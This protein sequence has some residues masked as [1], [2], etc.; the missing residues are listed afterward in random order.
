MPKH[1]K[2][3]ANVYENGF[4]KF[5]V[6]EVVLMKPELERW[7]RRNAAVEV[8]IRDPGPEKR[9]GQEPE[10]KSGKKSRDGEN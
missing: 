7:I 6:G 8:E 1:I 4:V 2:F 9:E 5:K 10:K 3:V